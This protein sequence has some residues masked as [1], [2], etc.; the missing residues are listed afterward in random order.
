MATTPL[1]LQHD[2]PLPHERDATARDLFARDYTSSVTR[3][4][5]AAQTANAEVTPLRL[6]ST[7]GPNYEPLSINCAFLG[8][9]DP[10]DV[11]VHIAA[12]HGIEGELGATFQIEALN[13]KPHLPADCATV[14]IH[15]LNPFG[16]AHGTRVNEKRVD[17]NRNFSG[18]LLRGIPL[19]YQ[20]YDELFNPASEVA[21]RQSL[22]RMDTFFRDKGGSK[23][24]TTNFERL[25][26]CAI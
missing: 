12:V 8:T 19:A 17:L 23:S 14:F 26:H 4:L 24:S 10:K 5:F 13:A 18:S 16:R 1:T 11:L 25:W 9:P 22:Q 15:A 2:G 20:E 6:R 3:F 21:L 7:A